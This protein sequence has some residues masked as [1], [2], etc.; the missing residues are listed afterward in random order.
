MNIRRP[1]A[2]GFY[3]SSRSE[4]IKIIEKSFLHRLGPGSLPGKKTSERVDRII[5]GI[6]PHAGYIYSGPIAAHLYYELSAIKPRTVIILGPSH[7]GY[8]GIAVMSEG[9]WE[10]PL[11]MVEIDRMLAEKIR[12]EAGR[13]PS[14]HSYIISDAWPHISEHSLEVQIPFLQY[15]YGDSFKIVPIVCG[16]VSLEKC[17]VIGGKLAGIIDWS[18]TIVI[19]STD[20]THYGSMYYGFAPVGDDDIN[21]ILEW[22]NATDGG[23]ADSIRKLNPEDTYNKAVK[24][25]MCGYI[26]VTILTTIAR[27]LAIR[28]IRVLK[29]ATSYDVQGSRDAIVGYLSM[30]FAF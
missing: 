17:L 19:A 13:D 25:T 8:P 24:T 29:Y 6:S 23:I 2:I 7:T 27:A 15:I 18:D 9:L 10:T 20:M 14:G 1:A 26:P 5:G 22:M 3:P 28:N 21:K 11:G 12:V 4:L 16:G 30:V